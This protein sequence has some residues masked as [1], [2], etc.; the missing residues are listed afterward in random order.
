M[1]K[2]QMNPDEAQAWINEIQALSEELGATVNDAQTCMS[3]V[4]ESSSGSVVDQ[5]CNGIQEMADAAKTLVTGFSD[6]VTAVTNVVNAGMKAMD[7]MSGIISVAA[8]IIGL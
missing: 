7:E 8:A 4:Q 5:L 6:M 3:T 2:V 1:S